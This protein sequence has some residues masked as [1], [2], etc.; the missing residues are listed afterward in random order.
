MFVHIHIC[1]GGYLRRCCRSTVRNTHVWCD[2]QMWQTHT[3]E[4]FWICTYI[5]ISILFKICI[6]VYILVQAAVCGDVVAALQEKRTRD[7]THLDVT[8]WYIRL[9]S[10][11][12]HIYIYLWYRICT[13]KSIIH[14]VYICIYICA[15]GYLQ[16][17]CR[18]TARK[19]HVWYDPFRRD[20][21]IHK[22][23]IWIC[24]YI[25][26]SIL[27][28]MD[29]YVYYKKCVYMKSWC[30]QT[31]AHVIWHSNVTVWYRKIYMKNIYVHVSE[32]A[33]MYFYILWKTCIYLCIFVQAVICG[34][35][36]AAPQEKRCAI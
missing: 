6:Y 27:W 23:N 19:T 11:Y 36:V 4:I 5:Y 18:G 12:V 8:V 24:A 28:N 14:S 15:G 1:A 26:I 33:H 7:L 21:L 34:D 20:S 10:E 2:S 9:I 32:Y 29:I 3:E 16:R 22:T 35:V 30:R 31:N 25:Y 13:Y 17:C